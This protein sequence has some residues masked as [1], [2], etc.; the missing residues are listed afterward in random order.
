M[1]EKSAIQLSL[2]L[3]IFSVF[4]RTSNDDDDDKHDQL[5]EVDYNK[6]DDETKPEGV[7]TRY[8]PAAVESEKEKCQ[9][10]DKYWEAYTLA[11][12]INLL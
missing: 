9:Y 10:A 4:Q 5:E 12:V 11:T 7:Y 2:L 6:Q 8:N 1:R 3:H